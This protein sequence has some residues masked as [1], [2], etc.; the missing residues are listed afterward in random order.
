MMVIPAI[1]IMDGQVVRLTQG[2]EESR[3]NYGNSRSPLDVARHWVEEGAE[4]LHVI[5]LDATL[6]RGDNSG[7][8]QEIVNDLSIPIQV[9]GGIRSLESAQTLLGKG[10]DRIILGSLAIKSPELVSGL[11]EENGKDRIVIALDH[12]QGIVLD[13]GWKES[14]GK[15]LCDALRDFISL[16][17]RWFLITDTS[18]D[19]TLEGPDTETYSK[20]SRHASIIASGGVGSLG[21]IGTLL[22]TGVKAIVVGKA[23]YEVV[24]TL[25]EAIRCVE[26]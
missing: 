5:D 11:C 17:L 8:V 9:G 22:G 16:G 10:V 13:K 18:R 23:L 4:Y 2:D 12:K 26:A 3:I 20:V 1:D 19:G 15:P 25:P 21:D 14:T 6:G 24:F 7:L